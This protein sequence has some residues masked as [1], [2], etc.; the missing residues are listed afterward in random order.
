MVLAP[1]DLS[2]SEFMQIRDLLYK[3]CGIDMPAGKEGLVKARLAKRL[4]HLQLESF[5]DYISYLKTDQSSHELGVMVDELTTNKTNFYREATHFEFLAEQILPDL[6]QRKK[7]RIWCAACSTGEEPY[8]LSMQVHDSVTNIDQVD[9]RILATDISPTVLK[10]AQAG[11]YEQNQMDGVGVE[12]K[13]KYFTEDENNGQMIYRVRDRVSS[14]ITFARL[15]LMHPWPM[16]GPFDAVFCRNVM[17]YF[18]RD[19]RE[20][21]INRF[22]EKLRPGGYLFVGHSES[23]SSLAHDFTY[24]QPAIYMK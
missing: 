18:D 2:V 6:Q 21:L 20:S 17:I 23:L 10:K 12:Q 14:M 9:V 24:V 15:N 5:A 22:Y 13:R 16:Q 11:L 1:I 3:I 8:T 4:K 7:M 19:T